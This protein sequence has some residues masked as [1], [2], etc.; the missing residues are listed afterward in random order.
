VRLR[1]ILALAAL[2]I[3]AALAGAFA[4]FRPD[5]A[6]TVATGFVA[7]TLCSSVFVSGLDADQ[8]FRES[9]APL[10]GIRVI[11]RAM[12]YNVDKRR[13]E[14]TAR[15]FGAF[16][17][18]AVYRGEAGC[19]IA[20]QD[21]YISPI[22][23]LTKDEPVPT[24]LPAIDDLVAGSNEKLNA[25]VFNAFVEPQRAPFRRTKAVVVVHDGKVVAERYGLGITPNT[26][27]LGYSLSHAVINAM[28]GI[29]VQQGKLS[30]DG[31]A[32]VPEWKDVNDPRHVISIENLMR[33]TSGL[34]LDETDSG[35][36]RSSQILTLEGDMGAAAANAQLVALPGMRWSYSGA[37]MMILSR[38]IKNTVGGQP[39]RVLQFA[40][41]ELFA[42]LGMNNMTLEFD[43]WGTPIGAGYFL[44]TARDWAKLGLL[45]LNNGEVGGKRILP[46]KWADW[47]A[48]PTVES[49]RGFGAGFWTNRGNS[50]GAQARVKLGMPADA[51][52]ASGNLG[53]RIII[54]P[55]AKL[56]V[57]WLGASQ[58]RP[59]Y[60]IEGAAA[61]V[62][63]VIAALNIAPRS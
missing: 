29:L 3:V 53:Q 48:T 42:P 47:S 1:T 19:V 51:Y 25:A 50:P 5:R 20:H 41:R 44:G 9:L 27:L 55:S 32:P 26:R 37:S 8:V 36:D 35:F 30:V 49:S 56:V 38:I 4:Y 18:Y 13:K 15:V 31:P 60:D 46:D 28:I 62:R 52:F 6:V 10:R 7:H 16:E 61:L 24:L 23:D 14:V 43:A 40:R 54:V 58:K 12:T 39:E 33:M 21:E 2:L 22:M 57:V 63:D 17:G 34:D 45:F 59:G 11:R